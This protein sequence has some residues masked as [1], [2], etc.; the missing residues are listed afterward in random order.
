MSKEQADIL[1]RLAEGQISTDEAEQQLL[2]LREVLPEPP[3]NGGSDEH[4]NLSNWLAFLVGIRVKFEEPLDWRLDGAG[5]STIRAQ[6]DNGT[7]VLRGTD[8]DEVTVRAWKKVRAPSQ[9]AARAFARQV[10]IHV[11]REGEEIR[12]CRE[13]PRPP[14]GTSVS[15]RY[16]IS[17]PRRVGANLCT[18]NGSVRIREVDG[19]VEA[20]T[21]NGSVELEGGTGDVRLHTSNGSVTVRD[22]AGRVGVETSNGKIR[23]SLD[24]VEEGTFTTSNGSIEVEVRGGNAPITAKASNGS[25]RLALPPHFAG[26]LDARAT[27]GHVHSE[28]PLAVTESSRHRLV[29]ELGAGGEA[30]VKLRTLNGSI[31]LNALAQG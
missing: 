17:A 27:H 12:V 15:V 10:Q 2:A 7:V 20:R 28:L 4:W 25:V 29:G 13:H 6:T 16:E 31:H 30:T 3:E 23:A 11:E 9:E 26:Q 19:P 8:Q 22:A 5:V 1:E 24:T 21:S 14:L 18:A